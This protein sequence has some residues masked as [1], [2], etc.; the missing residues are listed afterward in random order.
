MVFHATVMRELRAGTRTIAMDRVL[1]VEDDPRQRNVLARAL[2]ED[3]FDLDDVGTIDEARE[4]VLSRRYDVI[5]LDRMLPDGE[6]VDFCI[7]LRRNG[8][9]A[10][11][12]MLTA[13]GEL[14]D[15][16]AGLTVGA[17]AYLVKPFELDELR[18][19][20]VALIRRDRI[21][22]RFVDGAFVLDFVSRDAW[23]GERR[24]E[25]TPREFALLARLATE[26]DVPV[27]RADLHRSV[28][29]LSFDPGSGVL[30][31]HVS[32][33]RTKLEGEAW[34]LETVRNIGYRF[35]RLPS[36]PTV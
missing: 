12:L 15:R 18:A 23:S 6:G 31:V 30:E 33:L 10:P 27:S 32:R 25:L 11:V 28:W 26:A 21:G 1:I 16:V 24:L 17:D 3:G 2:R 35:R 22:T 29:Q 8:L 9:H 20:L 5:V 19:L 34:R 7:E 36:D 13:R 4:K 14:R